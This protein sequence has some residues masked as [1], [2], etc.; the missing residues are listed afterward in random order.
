MCFFPRFSE[1][2]AA[3]GPSIGFDARRTFELNSRVQTDLP[4]GFAQLSEVFTAIQRL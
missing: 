4:K 2:R 3:L 1:A